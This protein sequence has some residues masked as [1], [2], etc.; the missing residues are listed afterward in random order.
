MDIT[1]TLKEEDYLKFNLYHIKNS[2]TGIRAL[3]LQRFVPPLLYIV[4]AYLMTVVM[5]ASL[6]VMIGYALVISILWIVFYPCI[7]QTYNRSK[8]QENVKRRR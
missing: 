6:G 1:Y 7:F 4:L 5:E 2:K 8:C 3:N